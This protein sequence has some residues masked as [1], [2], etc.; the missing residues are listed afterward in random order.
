MIGLGLHRKLGL[1]A[2]LLGALASLA[3][4]SDGP[5]SEGDTGTETTT[6]T[7]TDSGDGDGDCTPPPGVFGDCASG[8]DA[9]M[10]D[11]PK[12]CILDSQDMAQ[13][14]VCGRPCA[15]ECDCWA[16]P[17]DGHAPVACIALAPGDDGT[18]VLDCSGG[19]TCPSGMI[20]DGAIGSELCLFPQ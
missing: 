10:T 15:D 4:C 12:Q 5:E 1:P 9:C 2:A 14:A 20:C 11:G 7:D 8:L 6:A 17:A 3:G 13:I 19:Q 18:C 16:P